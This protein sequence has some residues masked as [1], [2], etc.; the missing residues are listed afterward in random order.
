M[1][2]NAITN[3]I[4]EPAILNELIHLNSTPNIKILDATFV[5][6]EPEE[7]PYQIYM[8]SRIGNAI[9]FDINKIADSQ[10]DL[11]RMLPS[12]DKFETKVS[13]LGISNNDLIVIYGQAGMLMGAARAWLMFRIFGH[14]KVCILNGGLPAWLNERFMLN[15]SPTPTPVKTQFKAKFRPELVCNIDNVKR[16]SESGTAFILDA[17]SKERFNGTHP[18]PRAKMC[19]GHIP[20]S[21]NVPCKTLIKDDTKKLKSK[22]ELQDIFN[23]IGVGKDDFVI[24]TCGSGVTACVITFALY[25]I[26]NKKA[27]LYDGAWSEWG[28]TKLKNKIETT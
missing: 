25:H 27:V 10:S 2:D 5:L 28:R 19:C 6:T 9:F 15:N 24:T 13:D 14:D 26:G 23:K 7:T 1:I 11:P 16:E 8:K 22:K 3:G 18:E 21:N 12:S 17:R 20:R 4:I